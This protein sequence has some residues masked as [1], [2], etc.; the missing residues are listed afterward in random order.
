MSHRARRRRRPAQPAPPPKNQQDNH[1]RRWWGA[2]TK[3]V[4][5]AGALAGAI[6]AVLALWP[7]VRALRPA[8]DPKDGAEFMSI[9][10]T[11]GVPISEYRQRATL[12][13]ALGLQPAGTGRAGPV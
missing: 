12:A 3:A 5:T 8:P 10:V 1:S 11:A 4:L 13:R 7:S 9:D 2:T 6:A